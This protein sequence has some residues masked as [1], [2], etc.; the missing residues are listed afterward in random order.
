[1]TYIYI[2][3]LKKKNLLTAKPFKY[4]RVKSNFTL[5]T[6]LKWGHLLTAKPVKYG[7]VKSKFTL[8][9]HLKWG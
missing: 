9:T 8:E 7:R 6:H 4:G 3:I 1:M 5:E 2:Y